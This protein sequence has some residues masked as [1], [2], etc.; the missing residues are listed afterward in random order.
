M[1]YQLIKK[2]F[3]GVC[4]VALTFLTNQLFA[5][6]QSRKIISLGLQSTLTGGMTP[7]GANG[8]SL[9]YLNNKHCFYGAFDLY[10]MRFKSN[11]QNIPGYQLGYSYFLKDQEKAFN[12]SINFNMLY[13]Q[14]A[15]GMW[16]PV[17]Y[18]H[19]PTNEDFKAVN[20]WRTKSFV[21]TIGIG[22]HFKL[23]K[24]I[25]PFLV[26]A[27]G[28]NYF[29]TKNSPTNDTGYLGHEQKKVIPVIQFKLGLNVDVY[30]VKKKSEST[31]TKN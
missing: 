9:N 25:R 31:F 18:N 12:V 22:I 27:G 21:N 10:S 7:S 5:Q 8:I 15:N 11:S 28:Y 4:F 24:V 19:L 17:K 29:E 13:V 23:L 26:V 1:L 16:L 20:S 6:E 30:K 14:Y 2:L 3:F